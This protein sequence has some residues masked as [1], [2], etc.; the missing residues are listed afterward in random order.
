[1]NSSEAGER[2]R[3]QELWGVAEGT[4]VFILEKKMLSQIKGVCSEE[5]VGF[6]SGDKW[7]DTRKQPEALPGKSGKA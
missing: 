5:G 7:W 4:A 1:M 2:T 3:K 6:F